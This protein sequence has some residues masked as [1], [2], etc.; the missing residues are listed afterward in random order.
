[1][2]LIA[3]LVVVGLTA[4]G[5]GGDDADS[6]T[7]DA[8]ATTVAGTTDTTTAGSDAP[9][10]TAA[11]GDETT[12]AAPAED[13][14]P[15]VI[16]VSTE[17]STLDAQLVNDRS[18]RIFTDNI[19]EML[20]FRSPTNE[21]E[22]LL[23]TSYE[24]IDPTTWQFKLRD[25][26]TF[27]D[28]EPFNADAVVFSIERIISEDFDTQR[29]SY[30]DGITGAVKV[31]DTTVNITTDG[32]LATLPI[33]V[34]QIPM[35]PPN[36]SD[37]LDT[38]P[39][40]T[41]PYKFVSWTPGSEIVATRND[42]YWGDEPSISDFVVRIVGDNQTSLAALQSGEVDLVVDLLPEQ[43]DSVP[44]ALSIQGSEFSYIA[45]NSLRPE[46]SD[47]RV[48][49]AFNMAIDKQTL[50]DTVYEGQGTPNHAQNLSE[51]MLGYN[52]DLEP[53]PYDPDG[54]KALLDE[55]GYDYDAEIV[56]N[57][58]VGRYLKGEE[59]AEYVAAQ[60]GEV[61]VNVTINPIEFNTFREEARIPGDE[62]G[63]M[64]L[65]YGWNSNE[66]GD[67]SRILSHIT[68]GGSSSKICDP[69][70]DALMEDASTSLDP[71]QRA[72]DY[73]QVWALL[74]D[75]PYAIYL[76]QQ[77]LLYGTS[78]RLVWEPRIDDEYY[79]ST[80]SLTA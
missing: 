79:V 9:A 6:T 38:E 41:G 29:T 68:C 65:K 75:N 62:P 42:D 50:A 80:M 8:A 31:D 17:P 26:V 39:V 11:A 58:P 7:T 73:Q 22:P 77:N 78:D 1:M 72:S 2:R 13:V 56:L 5:C 10:T 23:A 35:V 66:F 28:G 12:T 3:A 69:A 40:G 51:G 32:V 45:F 52:P 16:A 24:N 64:D 19:Y 33:Q 53:I 43:M 74:R 46:L 14:D 55:A 61:G 48:R 67:G 44:K 57:V 34:T 30:I 37:T 47:P 70:V 76:L 71:D 59:T 63:A 36:A 21:I 54:A 49:V 15:L 4:A 20:L 60:L 25:D 27:H 18:S